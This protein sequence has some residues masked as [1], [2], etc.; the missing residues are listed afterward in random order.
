VPVDVGTVGGKTT[1]TLLTGPSTTLIQ[2]DCNGSLVI[3]PAGVGYY[4]V[5]YDRA[6]FAALAA[7]VPRLSDSTRLRLLSDTWS[8]AQSGRLPL[9]SYTA[10][11]SGYVNESRPAIWSVIAAQLRALDT[12]AEGAPEQAQ[13]RRFVTALARPA[14]VRLGWNEREGEPEEQR[15]LRPL[16]AALLVR[17]EDSAALEQ[18]RALFVSYSR[19][20]DSVSPSMVDVVAHAAGMRN[21]AANYDDLATRL[22]QAENGAERELLADALTSIADPALAARTLQLAL[23]DTL[24]AQTTSRVVQQVAHAGHIELAWAFA[25]RHRDALLKDQEA[26]ARNSLFP[27]LVSR[28]SDPAHADMMEAWVKLNFGPDAQAE[29]IKVGNE[30]RTRALHKRRLLPQMGEAMAVKAQA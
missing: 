23:S 4:R 6:S 26:V 9:A 8:Q 18:A 13:V 19:D 12:M 24:P 2:P 27:S 25:V 30:I 29:A 10:L 21:D 3:D 15:T 20:A 1:T 5:Q 11:V 17:A 22:A 14:F 7:Q 16:L 28:S